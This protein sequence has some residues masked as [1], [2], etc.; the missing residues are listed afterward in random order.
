MTT[1]SY[2]TKQNKTKK[3]FP[4]KGRQLLPENLAASSA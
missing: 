1:I 4:T 3:R 2:K